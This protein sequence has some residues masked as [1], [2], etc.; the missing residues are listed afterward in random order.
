M[1][2]KE[3]TELLKTKQWKNFREAIL[4]R[5]NYSC[6][7]C[8]S[9]KN[10]NVHHIK[11]IRGLKPWEYPDDLVITLCR[12]CH[13]KVH[14]IKS[15]KDRNSDKF[16][17][18]FI[19]NINSILSITGENAIKVLLWM[20]S[21]AEYNSGIVYMTTR[22]IIELANLLNKPRQSIYNSIVQLKKLDLISGERGCFQINPEIF[23]KGE[24]S[25]RKQL[26]DKS[27]NKMSI[28]FSLLDDNDNK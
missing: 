10:P 18:V 19:D 22:Q 25:V 15:K 12:D 13:A 16:F 1:N 4:L 8:G 23:W 9:I 17:A 21:I 27:G 20:C 24:L 5:D 7:V 2:K 26:L 11:Y 6:R 14:S 3:Y 28:T